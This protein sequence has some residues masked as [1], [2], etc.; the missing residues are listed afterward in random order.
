MEERKRNAFVISPVVLW[1][2]SVG[3]EKTLWNTASLKQ[4]GFF[5]FHNMDPRQGT[6]PPT[7]IDVV[8][9]LP[10]LKELVMLWASFRF[11]FFCLFCFEM[12]RNL[13]KKAFL[14]LWK[15]AMPLFNSFGTGILLKIVI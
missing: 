8:Q 11:D 9:R 6:A 4:G 3:E 10:S 1:I 2:V 5:K 15:K 13:W 12:K 14:Y 7:T